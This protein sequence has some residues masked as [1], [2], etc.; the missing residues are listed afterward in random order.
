MMLHRFQTQHIGASIFPLETLRTICE[1]VL[2]RFHWE[3]KVP[4]LLIIDT[5]GH[6]A[7]M[8]LRMRGGSVADIAIL[9]VDIVKG[10]EVQTHESIDLLKAR[11][12]PFI[13]AANKVDLIPGWKPI[14]DGTALA[15]IKA[16]DFDVQ[17]DLDNRIYT[18]MH[19]LNYLG[20]KADRYD[21]VTDFTKTIAIVPVSA[22][23]GEGIADLLSVLIGLTQQYMQR[24]LMVSSGPAEGTVL[25]VREEPG[26]GTTLNAII[27]N[28]VLR[29][30]DTIVLAGKDKP[31][32]VKVKALLVPK[33]LD[34]MRAPSGRFS[35][36]DEVPAAAGV[37]I[38]AQ[39]LEDALAGSPLYAVPSGEQPEAYT[40]MVADEVGRFRVATDKVGVILKADTLGS[41]EAL[42]VELEKNGVP[43]RMADIGEVSRREVVEAKVVHRLT[44]LYGVILAFNVGVLPDAMEESKGEIPVFRH[45][46][47]YQLIQSYLDWMRGEEDMRLR[48]A[49]KEMTLPGKV[50]IIPGYVFRRSKPAIVGVEVLA[51]RV[52][53]KCGLMKNEGTEVGVVL[54]VQDKGKNIPEA[55]KGME[56]AISIDGPIV[57]RHIN[58][59]DNLYVKVPEGHVKT[60]Q[61][62]FLSLLSQD[63][64]EALKE[65]IEVNRKRN[66]FWAL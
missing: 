63:D 5:P 22:K 54:Q 35:L 33:P 32:I 1:P 46:I 11:K 44:P 6:S 40:K 62:R 42:K 7:F 12:T 26:L 59:G 45:D 52:R 14:P 66:P 47:I 27:Y 25:E 64:L 65:T 53:P 50:R 10:L 51:G 29:Q 48:E 20:F 58:E 31:I 24:R 43:V 55:I 34:E 57:G 61:E 15:S 21:R 28:G 30:G 56:V 23:T 38:A 37:K 8:N 39:G 17:R 60:L 2:G 9:V 3:V 36:V 16:Q 4:G 41:L 13:I 49:F 19:A 18:F